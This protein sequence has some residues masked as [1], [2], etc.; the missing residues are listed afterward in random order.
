KAA[1]MALVEGRFPDQVS[2][3]LPNGAEPRFPPVDCKKGEDWAECGIVKDAGDDP[4]V[5]HGATIKARVEWGEQASGVSFAAGPGVGTVTKPG[6]PLA[7]G[8]PAINPVPRRMIEEAVCEVTNAAGLGPNLKVTLSVPN[9]EALAKR[10]WNPRLG[11]EGGIS[12][13]GTTGIVRPYSCAAWISAIH[14]GIDVAVAERLTHVIAAT[15]SNSE[16][17]ARDRH[18]LP[19]SACIDMG[20]FVGGTLKYLRRHPIPRL[21]LAGG[22]AKFTK[23]AMGAG[24]LHSKRSPVDFAALED[25][26]LSC[27]LP[28]QGTRDANTVLEV[29]E[30]LGQPFAEVVVQTAKQQSRT[31]LGDASIDME[32]IVVDRG[33]GILAVDGFV[34]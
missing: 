19:E 7:I 13:L 29:L 9:G 5:T 12:I 17:A 14:R 15:G 27:D 2:F 22:I 18:G 3:L 8:E 34:Q 1:A 20:D 28:A 4:D 23:L 26:L 30:R 25:W 21:T 31:M 16:R 10:T 24:D 33:G 6:L 11:I 32:V